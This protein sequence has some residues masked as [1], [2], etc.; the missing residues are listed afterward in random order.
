MNN[1]QKAKARML[2]G[3]PFFATLLLSTPVIEDRTIPTAATDMKVI[4]YNPDFFAPLTIGQIAFV[5]AHEVLHIAFAHGFRRMERHPLGW[6]IAA[7]YAINLL[8]KEAGFEFV[9]GGL[10]DEQYKGM[11]AE[12]IYEKLKQDQQKG[13][14]PDG[15]GRQ[16][17]KSGGKQPSNGFGSGDKVPGVGQDILDPDV[18]S[19]EDAVEAQR[20]I[21]QKV[22]QAANMARMAGKLSGSLERFVDEVLNPKVPWPALL[23][24]Y[25]TRVTHD[26]ESW[27]RRNR[28]FTDIY[29]PAR[30]NYRMGEIIVIGDT[31]GSISAE[32]LNKVGAEVSSISDLMQPERIRVLW[33]DTSVAKEQVFE[34]GEV[35]TFEPA[36]GGGTDMRVPLDH[37]EQYDPQVVVLITDGYTPWP[38]VPPSYPLIVCCTTDAAV[39]VGEVVRI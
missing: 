16:P 7:D 13:K 28:R 37:A 4:R 36:G 20:Q 27:S 39:P 25:M 38:D 2:I 22:A 14:G 32:E 3:H 19:P 24:D 12:Q 10:L 11:S 26:T 5:L 6:N 29:L 15:S 9:E 35:L 33:A 34:P 23:R 18:S 17:G 8:L 1:L 21:Q 30:H 31:S